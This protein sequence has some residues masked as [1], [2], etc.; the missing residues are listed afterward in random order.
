MFD[1]GR[2]TDGKGT[3]VHCKDAIFVMTSNLAQREIAQESDILR[4][5]AAEQAN[6]TSSSLK[7]STV[8]K[9][10][11]ELKRSVEH[12]QIPSE[13]PEALDTDAQNPCR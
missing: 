12:I 10:S 3:T 8:E 1:E 6:S 11:P 4:S 7:I 2:I 9:G 13:N 5:Y